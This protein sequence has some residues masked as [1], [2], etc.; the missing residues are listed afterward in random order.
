MWLELCAGLIVV[1]CMGLAAFMLGRTKNPVN[2]EK[3]IDEGNVRLK[4]KMNRDLLR[5]EVNCKTDASMTDGDISII[6]NHLLRSEEVEFV[7]PLTNSP[8]K[9]VMDDEKGTYTLEA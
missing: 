3:S 6:R 2:V 1:V 8:I 5:L 9:L 4:V 7:F